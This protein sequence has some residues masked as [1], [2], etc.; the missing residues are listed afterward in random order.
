MDSIAKLKWQCRRGT[1]ELDFLLARYLDNHF[2]NADKM[3]QQLFI[4]LLRFQDDTLIWFLLGEQR[5]KDQA[6]VTLIEK[7]R[8][9]ANVSD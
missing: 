5:P 1:K 6:L 4:E 3:E 8:D 2:V 7:I 9:N